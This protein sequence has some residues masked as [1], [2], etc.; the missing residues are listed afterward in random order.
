MSWGTKIAITYISFVVVTIGFV[1]FAMTKDVDL[2]TDNYYEKELVYQEQID[3]MTRANSL[4]EKVKILKAGQSLS[5]IFPKE[6]NYYA[7]E[8]EIHLYRPA[9]SKQDLIFP[10]QLDSSYQQIIN[11]TQI[12]KGMWKLNVD[13]NV[14]QTTYFNEF[15]VMVD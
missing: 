13:W 10:I 4:S 12:G 2:V 8:G 9:D 1:L 6:F 7:V 11:T 14:N 15:R 5:F 3:K